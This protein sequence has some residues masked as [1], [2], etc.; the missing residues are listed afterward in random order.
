MPQILKRRCN[1][2]LRWLLDMENTTLEQNL[3]P[4]SLDY[5][6]FTPAIFFIC[7]LAA[8]WLTFGFYWGN[9]LTHLMIIAFG[10]LIFALKVTRRGWVTTPNWV[11]SGFDYN[12]ITHLPTHPKEGSYFS[13]YILLIDLVS[14][15]GWLYFARYWATCLMQLF[16][17][18]VATSWIL[19]LIKPLFLH[20]HNFKHKQKLKRLETEKSF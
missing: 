10:L 5:L 16:V 12:G 15:S 13:C 11:P 9:N 8:R 4:K 2:T 18:Q 3:R 1:F 17:N 6:L 20:D 19:K 7:C 14:L